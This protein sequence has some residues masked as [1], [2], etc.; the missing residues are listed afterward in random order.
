[1]KRS[2]DPW[3][4]M[5]PTEPG[6]QFC[7]GCGKSPPES[8]GLTACPHCGDRLVPQGFCPVCEQYLR[9]PIGTNC[10]KHD[11]PLEARAPVRPQFD[12]DGRPLRWA[13]VG[14]FS[15]SMAAEA[16]RIRLE[17]EGIPTFVEGERMGARSMYH[18]ATGGVKLKV[19]E[20]LAGDARIILSQT[21]SATA[22]ELDIEENLDD[23]FEDSRPAIETES[24]SLH[25]RVLHE[26]LWGTIVIIPILGLLYLLLRAVGRH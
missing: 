16:P 19:P 26:M 10:P 18:V 4:T 25:D 24:G 8:P 2:Q 12:G 21:W 9:L 22:A 7:S 13:T 3:E 11:L 20:T 14:H 6:P 1:M 17:A 15:D 5:L 23:D